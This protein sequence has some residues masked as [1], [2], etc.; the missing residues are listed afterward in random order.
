MPGKDPTFAHYWNDR[1]GAAVPS[2]AKSGTTARQATANL[3]MLGTGMDA[4]VNALVSGVNGFASGD[5]QGPFMGFLGTL[6]GWIA[7][8]IRLPGFASGADQIGERRILGENGLKQ[9]AI[10][11]SR[12]F[13]AAQTREI[14]TSRAP[15]MVANSNAPAVV[16]INQTFDDRSSKDLR[17]ETEETSDAR[18]QRQQKFIISDAT[19]E[20]ITTPGGRG[21]LTLQQGDGLRQPATRRR[22][23]RSG[24]HPCRAPNVTAD[25]GNPRRP[26][27]RHRPIW[28][29]RTIGAGFRQ[30]LR[31]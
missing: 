27:A 6:A 26:G 1:F 30:F 5:P 15:V 31:R 21:A 25:S 10:G 17:V 20:G 24:L 8:A 14:V 7:S 9:E 12:V 16:Q 22:S 23:S 28:G 18:G 4:F 29:R 11:A 19:T 2:L 3:G 13:D